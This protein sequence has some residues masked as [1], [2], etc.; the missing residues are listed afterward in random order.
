MKNT[1]KRKTLPETSATPAANA[2][3]RRVPASCRNNRLH[4]GLLLL[5]LVCAAGPVGVFA[6]LPST[7]SGD[8][9]VDAQLNVI[10]RT[11]DTTYLGGSFTMIGPNCPNG[12]PLSATSGQPVAAYPK[13]NAI[14]NCCAPDGTGG[15]YI[16]GNFTKVGALARNRLAHIKADGTVDAAWDPNANSTVKALTVSGST[17]YVGGQFTTLGGSARNRLAAIGTDG[18]LGTWDPNANNTVNALAV[19]GSTVY[20]GGSFTTC[21]GSTRNC[22]AAIGTDGTLSLI[23]I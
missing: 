8:W 5:A 21:G 9:V 6:D 2:S 7:P 20:V 10:V 23:H 3:S 15:W 16:G 17:V 1:H 14:V 19:S 11:A 13:V 22:L 12:V 18:A 4:T